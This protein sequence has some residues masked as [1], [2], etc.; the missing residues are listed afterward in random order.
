MPSETIDEWL[1]EVGLP[2]YTHAF[3]E[4]DI[5]LA[6][7]PDLSEQDLEKLGVS[8][9]H[10]K[11]LLKAIVERGNRAVTAPSSRSPTRYTPVHLAQR[12]LTSRSALEGERKQVTV[13][14]AD[15][16]GSMELLADRDPE[17]ARKLLDPVLE[18]MMEAVHRYEGTV[19]QVMGDG[20]MALFG[21]P[22]AHEDHAV[23]ACY[24]ALRMQEEV[25]R[26][27]DSLQRAGA[28]PV[29]IRVGLNSGEV[30]VRSIG[31]DLHMDYT[32]VGQTTHLASRIENLARAGSTL[33]SAYTLALAEGYVQVKPL[34]RVPIK[35]LAEE[36]ELFELTGIGPA[37]S[38]IQASAARGLSKFVG[39][40][41]EIEALRRALE[42][43]AQGHGQVVAVVGEPGVGKS[44]LYYEFT[45]SHRM[46]DWL[47]LEASSVS[48]G[49]A[50]PYLP[51]IDLLKDYFHIG[52]RDDERSVREKITGKLLA[53]D[54]LLEPLIAPLAALL[55]VNVS[56][57]AWVDLDPPRRR[58]E[59]LDALKRL[60][61]R[62]AQTQP[63]V[64]MFEDL[65]WIDSETQAF[66][67]SLI[68]SLP[69]ARLL[70]LANFR[71][72]YRH[73]W[74]SKRCFT[75]LRVDSLPA[76]GAEELLNALLG[77]DPALQPLKRL[78]VERTEGNPFFI[79]E[80][81]RTLL[82]IGALTGRRGEYRCDRPI[83]TIQVPATAQA[84]LGARID[85]LS[86]ENKALL[87]TAAVIGKDVPYAL[88]R[89][90]ALLSEEELRTRLSELQ[91][92]EFVY[93]T[94][95]FPDLEYTFKHALTHDV[96]YASLLQDRR[97]A[98]HA[99]I[100]ESIETLYAGNLDEHA[101]RLAHHALHAEAWEKALRYLRKAASKASARWVFR[102]AARYLELALDVIA[103]LPNRE[104]VAE[105][106]LDIRFDLRTA[107]LPAARFAR[108][109]EVIESAV[110]LAERVGDR[111]RLGWAHAYLAFVAIELTQR[112]KALQS[113]RQALALSE[114]VGEPILTLTARHYLS[115]V[116]HTLGEYLEAIEIGRPAMQ[117]SDDVVA[118]GLV[119]GAVGVLPHYLTRS[120]AE[121]GQFDEA[122]SNSNL[123]MHRAD[124]AGDPLAI[125][126]VCVG[127]GYTY[128]RRGVAGAAIAPLERSIELCR[129][130]GIDIQ[131]PWTASTLGLAYAHTG[132]HEEAVASAEEAI[133]QADALGITRYQPLR[134]SMLSNVYLL[135]GRCEEA[136]AMAE[137]AVELAHRYYEKG[138]AAWALYLLAATEEASGSAGTG[139]GPH[140]TY[141][142]AL[143]LAEQLCM[144]PLT[145]HCHF[146]LGNHLALSAAGKAR[147][148]LERALALY[149]KMSMQFWLQKTQSAPKDPG[150]H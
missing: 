72:E 88:L 44:R 15:L 30:V 57:P 79:E 24:A 128:V 118:A 11:K 33:L 53:L 20:I 52:E 145:A 147:E 148:H 84:L 126:L 82:E 95:L 134:L 12:I 64:V 137:K 71:P 29:Q 51:A 40:E 4:N 100:V 67:D 27:S 98:L 66:L 123:A 139:G 42:Q 104:V 31:S 13:L 124:A 60:L 119:H 99:R 135:C 47:I 32:A 25:G 1:A 133:K 34:G 150:K 131:I 129:A 48:Y 16:K 105:Q 63:L 78:L 75:Q 116:H 90:I 125:S 55:G 122:V 127:L 69:G 110:A 70:L 130:Y 49:K 144:R 68:D 138:S 81:V 56:D 111:R 37:R 142:E 23:R 10:R 146:G 92:A 28:M 97:R 21:A 83:E 9:G 93:E 143:D 77:Q 106:E 103:R 22:L 109:A 35:G 38:R 89:E 50:T 2:Q 149:R 94:S 91:A 7:L 140:Q 46:R 102:E 112:A 14:F 96:A 86:S 121:V 65:H 59:T 73:S 114:E 80:S 85:R 3:A 87:H 120:Q 108:I 36:A 141:L 76:D 115:Q 8:M 58:R 132:R 41:S 39:R 117:V 113:A 101:E 5:D 26:H 74:G 54:R 136:H 62:E 18:R 45:H 61:L 19:N 43:A 17:E 6:V 107:L